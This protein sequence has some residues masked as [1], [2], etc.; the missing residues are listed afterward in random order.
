MLEMI[1]KVVEA[2]EMSMPFNGIYG[3]APLV[4]E[5]LI[6]GLD[7]LCGKKERTVD[8]FNGRFGR[9]RRCHPEIWR[10]TL[11]GTLYVAYQQCRCRAY[12][13]R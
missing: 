2:Q 11:H 1:S 13:D 6:A 10:W 5:I 7:V 4:R 9:N 3:T 12:A 8:V